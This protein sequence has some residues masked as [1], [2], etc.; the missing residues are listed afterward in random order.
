M[1]SRV[2]E[3]HTPA[4][5]PTIPHHGAV[6]PVAGG[7]RRGAAAPAPLARATPRPP[8]G[9]PPQSPSCAP[10]PPSTPQTPPFRR[11]PP[12]AGVG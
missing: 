5:V 2:R 1:Y 6:R 4:A 3:V 10:Q 11:C 7:A 12:S 9:P 8:R